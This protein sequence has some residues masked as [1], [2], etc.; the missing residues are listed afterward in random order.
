MAVF[1]GIFSGQRAL[2]QRAEAQRLASAPRS[3]AAPHAMQALRSLALLGA[4]GSG[5]SALTQ[6]LLQ[7]A[8]V[9]AH[10]DPDPLERRHHHT[11]QTAVHTG[12]YQGVTLQLLDTPG[13]ADFIGQALPALGAVD[14][15]AIVID[16]ATGPDAQALQWMAQAEQR[17]LDR[18]II[19]NKID[20]P[21]CDP[22][23]TLAR[24]QATWGRHCLPLNLP[25]HQGKEVVDCWF[26]PHATSGHEPDFLSVESAHQ[27]LVEQ[28]VEVDA[29]FVERYLTEG[30]IDPHELH[31]PLEQALREGHLV[32]VCFVSARSGAGV[33]ELLAAIV[34]LLPHPGE[35]NPP[36][37]VLGVG[38]QAQ[39]LPVQAEPDAPLLAHVFKLVFDPYLGKLGVVRVHQ[40]RLLREAPLY[41]GAGR[42]PVRA[43]HLYRLQGQQFIEVDSALPGE[44]V[45]L[46]KLD[47]AQ[48]YDVL[49]DSPNDGQIHLHPPSFPRPVHG[50][51]IEP[52]RHG[53]EQRLWET[54][55]KLVAEDPCLR[56]E[57]HPQTHESVVYSLGELHL[58]LLLERLGDLHHF[59]LLTRA[60]RIAY[61][62]TISAAA[63]G[64]HRHKKQSGGAGQFGEV[65][66]R[67]EPLPRGSG[68]VFEDAVKGGA[69]PGVYMPAVEKGVRLAA[70]TGV[71]SGHP[72]DDLK[73]IILDGKHHSVDSKE[74]A[75]VT[76]GRKA[77]AEAVR[78]AQPVVLEPVVHMAIHVPVH[79]VGDVTGDLASR[80]G[81]VLGTSDLSSD[82]AKQRAEHTTV[83]ARVPLAELSAYQSRLNALTGGQG[84]YTYEDSHYAIVPVPVQQA[85]VQAWKPQ[86]TD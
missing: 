20:E 10:T 24:I 52:K 57:R 35:G 13:L 62:E 76:A 82:L 60:P 70:Q 21:G 1:P 69:I 41:L 29:G 15:A 85:L 48:L 71:I 84:R 23:A 65:F 34:H 3:A 75:F 59:E 56:L 26:Q 38:D 19:V 73:V 16:A 22:A 27:A 8:G 9:P 42:K 11:L 44:L 83:R 50:L 63:E 79:S 31:A 77:L 54:L 33:A 36:L 4:S 55:A 86:E 74:I 67:V 17:G 81:E 5:K 72:V 12:E 2:G 78:A 14:T 58:R 53:D 49:H 47:E 37:M 6:A 25:A 80:R 39:A 40:G 18:L 66:L 68:L 61:R 51:V 30:D 45:A 32:P 43:S 64:H 7:T 46:A 28:V